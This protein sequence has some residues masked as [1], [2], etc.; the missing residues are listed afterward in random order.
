MVND[1]LCP[2][3]GYTMARPIED[4]DICPSCGTEF[5]VSDTNASIEELRSA[6]LLTGPNWWS[7]SDPRPVSWNPFAQFAM[8]IP[9]FQ[10]SN[11]VSQE[12]PPDHFKMP[13]SS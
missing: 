4:Y 3:C 9:R 6:W 5:G 13:L 11:A 12:V 8:F 10:N 2:V 1:Q 7:E